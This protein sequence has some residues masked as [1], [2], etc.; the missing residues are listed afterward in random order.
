[1]LLL[2]QNKWNKNG[3]NGIKNGGNDRM[4]TYRKRETTTVIGANIPI[5]LD[6][7]TKNL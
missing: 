3:K 4:D 1:M 2:R 5:A 7:T 6:A